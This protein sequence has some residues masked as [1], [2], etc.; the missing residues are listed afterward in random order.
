MPL[1]PGYPVERLAYL[2][3]DSNAMLALTRGTAREVLQAAIG[4]LPRPLPR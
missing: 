1:D 3:R 2:L 4:E